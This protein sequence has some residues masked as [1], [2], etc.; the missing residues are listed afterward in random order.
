MK[1]VLRSLGLSIGLAILTGR[2]SGTPGTA[3]IRTRLVAYDGPATA[4]SSERS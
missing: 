3:S 1:P 4:L 2:Q